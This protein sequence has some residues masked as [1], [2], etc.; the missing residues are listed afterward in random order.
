MTD[1]AFAFGLGVGTHN[2][3]GEWLEV[4]FP[5][6]L[7]APGAALVDAVSAC[8]SATALDEPVLRKLKTALAAAGETAQAELAGRLM[9]SG[10]PVVASW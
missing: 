9:D 3:K 10:R 6:P 2:S 1:S 7:L 4:F 8:D 5:R